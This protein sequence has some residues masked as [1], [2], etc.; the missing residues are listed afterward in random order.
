MASLKETKQRI[1]SVRGTRKVTSAMK[2][3]SSAKLHKAQSIILNMLPYQ[4][5]LETIL[6]NFMSGEKCEIKS[7]Y[8]IEKTK[9]GI[10]ETSNSAPK[11][12]NK[13]KIAIIVFSSNSALCGAFNYNIIKEFTSSVLSFRDQI[14]SE[15]HD[16]EDIIDVYPIGKKIEDAVKKMGFNIAY[17]PI[18]E[19]D[20]LAYQHLAAKPNYF[21]IYQLAQHL[22]DEYIK[23][24]LDRV[25]LIY[26][27]F[28]S[29][30]VQTIENKTYL[31]IDL[32]DIKENYKADMSEQAYLHNYIVEPSIPEVLSSLIPQ[33]LVQKLY[34]AL[35]DSF[36][37]EHATR[38]MAMQVA[39]DNA[40]D[41]IS[42]L[43]IL[44]NKSRQQAITAE[45]LDI[46]AGSVK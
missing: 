30:G 31:P 25:I 27:H 42:E 21:Q 14:E 7:P 24:E 10:L 3:V 1:A 36:A 8:I 33:V 28:K 5:K 4:K 44:Y 34:T 20:I 46:V 45:L 19:D 13:K 37:S 32:S 11:K 43:T 15:N 22:M 23:G 16:I 2:M 35:A 6:S 40:D 12:L 9:D 26:H 17:S 18:L 41:L 39:T 38:T 29:A